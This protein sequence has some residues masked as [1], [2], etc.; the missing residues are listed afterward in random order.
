[1]MFETRLNLNLPANLFVNSCLDY[2]LLVQNFEN[3]NE[4]VFLFSY[5][6]AV[7]KLP[8]TKRLTDFKVV[9]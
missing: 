6:I 7:S 9:N 4:L 8:F 2:L 5:K 3:T 1:M